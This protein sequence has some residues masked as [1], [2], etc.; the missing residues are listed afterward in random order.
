MYLVSY[1]LQGDAQA[2][3]ETVRCS[4]R[5][6]GVQVPG[7]LIVNVTAAGTADPTEPALS[8]SVIVEVTAAN[9]LLRL[10]KRAAHHRARGRSRPLDNRKPE[11]HPAF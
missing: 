2:G 8:H 10:V 1:Y 4:L 5:L 6:N 7:S 9:S 11:R 3:N